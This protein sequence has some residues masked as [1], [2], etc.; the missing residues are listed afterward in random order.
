MRPSNTVGALYKCTS[1]P[2]S[3]W[4][5]CFISQKKR[6]LFSLKIHIRRVL[7]LTCSEIAM[8]Y[9]SIRKNCC[10]LAQ[11]ATFQSCVFHMRGKSSS[12]VITHHDLICWIALCVMSPQGPQPN[13]LGRLLSGNGSV[14][15]TNT[16]DC[17]PHAKRPI[18]LSGRQTEWCSEPVV[19]R[20]S[21]TGRKNQDRAADVPQT[22]GNVAFRFG[23][24]QSHTASGVISRSHQNI[25]EDPRMTPLW[26][27]PMFVLEQEESWGNPN[28]SGFFLLRKTLFIFFFP[29]SPIS[30]T[31][32][33]IETGLA[34]NAAMP[35]HCWMSSDT[36]LAYLSTLATHTKGLYR[37]VLE[38]QSTRLC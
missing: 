25:D 24:L 34:G 17:V 11:N 36:A 15:G 5:K 22:S 27:P 7:S 37:S 16:G 31:I 29:I 21:W 33:L 26:G 4:A 38:L 3:V 23:W 1:F 35:F 20:R 12:H 9:S 13:S 2:V 32:S 14:S 28:W 18:P 30:E 8:F 6:K 10:S 19:G